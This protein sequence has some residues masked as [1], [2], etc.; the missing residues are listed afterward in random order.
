VLS[1]SRTCARGNCD[2]RLAAAV[3]QR[4]HVVARAVEMRLDAPCVLDQGF[5]VSGGPEA[6]SMP[7]EQRQPDVLLQFLEPLRQCRLRRIERR[8]GLAQVAGLG[9][10]QQDLQMPQ[11]QTIG[12]VHRI[13]SAGDIP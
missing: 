7:V 6:A 9:K 10:A 2:S 1:T 11:T 5:A 12:P 13:T 3:A 4:L 8:R